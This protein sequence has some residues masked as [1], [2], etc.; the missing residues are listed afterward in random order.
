MAR[1]KSCNV[2]QAQVKDELDNTLKT[3]DPVRITSLQKFERVRSARTK[4]QER[5]KL[6]LSE[7]LGAKH[8]RVMALQAK[9]DSNND[10]ARNLKWESVRAGTEVPKLESD[11]W[12]V[13]GRISNNRLDAVTGMRAA[14]YDRS[15]CPVKTCGSD[16]TDKTG[17]FNLTI[18]NVDN[19][20]PGSSGETEHQEVFLYILNKDDVT[21]YKDKRPLSIQAGQMQ[22]LE[23]VLNDE[24]I[25]RPPLPKTRYLGNA[26]SGE[27]H[28]ISKQKPACNINQIKVDHRVTFRTQ[29]Q[30]LAQGYDY[31]AHCF[32][33]DKSKR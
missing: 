17:Y 19:T 8:P 29:K 2:T 9:I 18:K 7:K 27:L 26:S 21:V 25:D 33:K 16:I 11:N 28:D 15:G 24:D 1:I 3:A 30:A 23:T 12:L 13:H 32:G 14:L 5:E 10:I 4:N 6:R 20:F 31:C 22:Y